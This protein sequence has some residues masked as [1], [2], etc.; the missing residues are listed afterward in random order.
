M[1]VCDA[2][3]SEAAPV[4][5]VVP[6]YRCTATVERAVASVAAQTWRPHEIILVDDCSGDGT[7]DALKRIQE[8]MPRGWIRV[9]STPQNEGAASARNVGW[10]LASQPYVAFL[11]ADDTWAPEKIETQLGWMTANPD[12]SITGHACPVF[13]ENRP[14]TVPSD[15][16]LFRRVPSNL[17][18]LS[19]R[20]CTSTVIVRRDIGLR[21]E[22]GKRYSE[23]YLLWL[24][25][26]LSGH[27]SYRSPLPLAYI[28][29]AAF[30]A[31]GLSENVFAMQRGELEVFRSL[32]DM[33]L[34]GGATYVLSCAFSLVK[35]VRRLLITSFR[36]R[37]SACLS[38]GH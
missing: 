16:A 21:F 26:S 24:K 30:G 36:R 31:G 7:R 3:Q 35:F 32:R 12:V 14:R 6:C 17:M 10:A 8:S 37:N 18:L 29:K 23:D 38:S 13:E 9:A 5:V 33:K 15:G 20:F 4:S 11:D 25:L 28:H 34:I 27:A 19:N 2:L 1:T 22:A